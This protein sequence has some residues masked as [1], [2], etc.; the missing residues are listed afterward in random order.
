MENI[1]NR[2]AKA[3]KQEVTARK[4]DSSSNIVAIIAIIIAS[5][6]I[7]FSCISYQK[8]NTP[9]SPV[10]FGSDG[11]GAGFTEGSIADVAN[12]VSPSVV[13]ILTEIKTRSIFG[14]SYTSQ[15]AGT[16]I[17]ASADGYIVTNKHVIEDASSI[18][19]VLADGTSYEGVRLV[20]QDPLND[21]AFLKID[22]VSDLKAATFGDSKTIIVG[23]QVIAI[24]NALGEFKNTVTAGIISGSGRSVTASDSNGQNVETLTDMIQTDAAINAG[25]SGGPLVNA[26]GEVIGINTATSSNAD[27]IGFAIPIS[28]IKGMLAALIEKG[29]AE[30]VYLGIYG[31]QITPSVAKHY[32]LPVSA[33][34][35]LYS[36]SSYSS[37]IVGSP[38]EKAGLKD[39]DIITAI[40]GIKVGQAGSVSSLLGEYKVGDTVQLSVLRG[41]TE[42]AINVTL[43]AYSE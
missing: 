32:N 26:A 28:S 22:N 18:S 15:A 33:G 9:L 43:E 31:I 16:G 7:A 24:G 35:Y 29:T 38:A 12:K 5:A 10:V 1:L 42:I 23:Q 19:V 37:I 17:I 30:R 21:V 40:N 39:K 13:S 2:N 6:S 27:G 14:Q 25:N 34:A 36:S 3:V 4:N 41:G 20:G 8:S 11:N